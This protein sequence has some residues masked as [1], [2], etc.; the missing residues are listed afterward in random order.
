MRRA[1]RVG[2]LTGL[3]ALAGCGHDE[4]AVTP[5]VS[6]SIGITPSGV[7][8]GTSAGLRYGPLSLGLSL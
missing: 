3:V 7:N 5:H 8:V 6:T 4:E 2:L 1:A